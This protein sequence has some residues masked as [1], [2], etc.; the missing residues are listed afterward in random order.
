MR[1][2]YLFTLCRQYN[3]VLIYRDS[4]EGA[5]TV[6]YK[7]NTLLQCLCKNNLRDNDLVRSKHVIEVTFIKMCQCS[8]SICKI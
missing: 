1:E 7:S 6:N 4:L 2:A 5:T 3:I 8:T